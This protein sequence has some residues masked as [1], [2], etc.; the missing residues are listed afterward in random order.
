MSVVYPRQGL[1]E[2]ETGYPITL[3]R[4]ALDR[5]EPDKNIFLHPSAINIP[6]SKVL[7]LIEQ[8]V[9]I[10]VA[11]YMSNQERETNLRAIPV[12]IYKGYFGYRVFWINRDNTALFNKSL[13]VDKLKHELIGIQ[14]YDWPDLEILRHNGYNIISSASHKGMFAMLKKKRVDYFPR[15]LLEAWPEESQNADAELLVEQSLLLY[16]PAAVFFFVNKNNVVL[17]NLLESGLRKMLKDGSFDTLFETT[18][19]AFIERTDIDNRRI[20]HL[21]NPFFQHQNN[22][23]LIRP[24]NPSQ[25]Q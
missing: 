5:A 13:P 19:R 17:A 9:V 6:Q 1:N 10:D 7:R 18:Q 3:L 12:P 16:Y 8:G 14:G 15:A 24:D 2:H 20:I 21:E 22:P 25:A 11:W 4:M 23:L